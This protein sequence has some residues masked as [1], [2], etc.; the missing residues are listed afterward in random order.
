MVTRCPSC[1]S[2]SIYED[3]E[4]LVCRRCDYVHKSN[5]LIKEEN[6]SEKE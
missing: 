4:K 6:E 5:K 1:N 2:T 3:G